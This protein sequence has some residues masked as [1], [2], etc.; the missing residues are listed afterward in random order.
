[1]TAV[2]LQV[3]L[4]STRL[5][6]KALI[7]IRN[8]TIIEHAMRALK[9]IGTDKYF[10]LTTKECIEKLKPLADKWGF[11]LFSGSKDDVLDR[12]VQAARKWKIKPVIRATGVNPLVSS[13]LAIEVLRE[14]NSLSAEYSNWTDAP[15][16]TG[17]EIIETKALVKADLQTDSI[18]D[19]EHVTPWIYNNPDRFKLNIKIGKFFFYRFKNIIIRITYI[20]IF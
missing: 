12:F 18:Y 13:E 2:F 3:R 6:E 7:K 4:D 9:Q 16:G 15:L 1:M 10:L 20:Y 8:L 11:D 14:H 17:I 5:P 19:R